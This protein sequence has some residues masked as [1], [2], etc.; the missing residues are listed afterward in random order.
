MQAR[1]LRMRAVHCLWVSSVLA[2]DSVTILL[3]PW[4]AALTGGGTW[5]SADFIAVSFNILA[6]KNRMVGRIVIH[7]ETKTKR[8]T[9]NYFSSHISVVSIV[10]IFYNWLWFNIISFPFLYKMY[11]I[12]YYSSMFEKENK[13]QFISKT[14]FFLSNWP[15][16]YYFQYF[17]Y[18]VIHALHN[19]IKK[20]RWKTLPYP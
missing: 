17:I 1:V 8:V 9:H 15:C 20:G 11:C 13:W 18:L 2:N 3:I 6:I 16:F 12:T 14:V 5:L 19:E 7:P 10:Y 4:R